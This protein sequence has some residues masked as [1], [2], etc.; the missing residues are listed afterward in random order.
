MKRPLVRWATVVAAVGLSVLFGY[1]AVR[2]VRWSSTWTALRHS[3]YWWLLPAFA[4]FA[5]STFLRGVRWRALFRPEAAPALGPVTKATLLGLF[6]N[7]ILPGRAGEAARVVALKSYGGVS[8]AE[9]A[10]SLARRPR[11]VPFVD[12]ETGLR[13]AASVSHGLEAARRPKHASIA[14]FWTVASW[15]LAGVSFW[16]LMIGF[17][18][19]LPVIAG[20]LTVVAVGLSFLVPAAPG[21]LGVFEAA[22][23]AATHA[24]GV[25]TSRAFA[26]VLVLHALNI[27]PYIVAGLVI[28]GTEMPR[29]RRRLIPDG[30]ATS[31]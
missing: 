30:D 23:L 8:R 31:V 20:M 15:V 7:T 19:H 18:L 28:L 1:F 22:G 17:Q 24:Y 6:F 4:A 11:S 10:A 25:P 14:A 5:I 16:F 3:N 26:Y 21:G 29:R 13:L 2:H 27:F 9:S 12:P